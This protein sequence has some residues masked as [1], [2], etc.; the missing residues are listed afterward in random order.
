MAPMAKARAWCGDVDAERAAGDLV[1][2]HRL[3]GAA[4]RLAAEADR[5]PVGQQGEAKIR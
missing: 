3:P 1:L 4:E 2:A 5:H